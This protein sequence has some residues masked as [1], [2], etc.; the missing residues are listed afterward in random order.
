MQDNNLNLFLSFDMSI[1]S[2]YIITVKGNNKSEEYSNRCQKS[3]ES[4]GMPFKVWNAYNGIDNIIT[5]P[6]HL[7]GNSF[8]KMLKISDHYLTRGE[9]ACALSHISLWHQCVLLDKPIVILE[10]DAIMLRKIESHD[11]F[12]SIIYLGGREWVIQNWPVLPVPPHASEGRN[13]RFICRAH[14]YSIDPSVAK[15]MLS[16]V[17]KYGICAPLDIMLRADIFNITHRGVYAFDHNENKTTDTTILARP[18]EGRSTTRN[19]DLSV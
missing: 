2:A 4:V 7:E 17:L 12:N 5:T 19:D 11:A 10:H 16:H 13:Y 3:C 6:E 8:M 9:V 18:T 15:N 1:E 14:A